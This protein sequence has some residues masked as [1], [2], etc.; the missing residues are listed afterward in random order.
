M[1]KYPRRTYKDHIVY[2]ASSA[3]PCN[4]YISKD[5]VRKIGFIMTYSTAH[6]LNKVIEFNKVIISIKLLERGK[7]FSRKITF[8]SI[9]FISK[10]YLLLIQCFTDIL[11]G[12]C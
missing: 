1:Q 2:L 11:L 9:D 10:P 5:I 4:K 12:H 8:L 3:S 6:N 7:R